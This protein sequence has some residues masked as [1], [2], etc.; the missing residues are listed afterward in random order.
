MRISLLSIFQEISIKIIKHLFHSKHQKRPLIPLSTILF[1]K[2]LALT[3][4]LDNGWNYSGLNVIIQTLFI[5]FIQVFGFISFVTKFDDIKVTICE[6]LGLGFAFSSFQI[7]QKA[8][9]IAI[10]LYNGFFDCDF[11][12][13]HI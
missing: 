8:F 1:E 2:F 10:Y 3:L 11:V 6:L 9:N 4:F 13:V 7:A 5:N 12:I